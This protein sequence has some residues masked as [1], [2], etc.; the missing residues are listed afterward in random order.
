MQKDVNRCIIRIPKPANMIHY[1]FHFLKDVYKIWVDFLL[2]VCIVHNRIEPLS[3]QKPSVMPAT[4]NIVFV[5]VISNDN[6][7]QLGCYFVIQ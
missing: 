2:H 5:S 1:S 7:T 3:K 6:K 4:N